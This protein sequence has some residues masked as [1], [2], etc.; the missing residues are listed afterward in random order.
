MR[1][2]IDAYATP[3]TDAGLLVGRMLLAWIFLHEGV[4]LLM[5]FDA[6]ALSMAKAGVPSFALAATVALQLAAGLSIAAGFWTRLGAGALAL[7]C[8][9]TATAFHT[10][11]AI[12]NELLHFEKDLALAGGLIVLMI[13]G[14]GAWSADAIVMR[15]AP[16]LTLHRF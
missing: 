14:A 6:A 7:F 11:F 5:N 16:R 3:L 12:R 8:L 10:N 15:S 2:A 13:H 4:Y 9:M 1:F